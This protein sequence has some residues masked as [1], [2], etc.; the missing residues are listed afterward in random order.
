MNFPANC[1]QPYLLEERSMSE[2]FGLS[3]NNSRE[4]N[5]GKASFTPRSFRTVPSF[6]LALM[7]VVA[8]ALHVGSPAWAGDVEP[9][10]EP[11]STI[12]P[13]QYVS[14]ML[15]L[16]KKPT[17]RIEMLQNVRSIVGWRL[18][19]YDELY[20]SANLER[21]FGGE[22]SD[23]AWV[24]KTVWI[25]EKNHMDFI[26]PECKAHI[27]C[28][29]GSLRWDRDHKGTWAGSSMIDD[30]K[31]KFHRQQQ[32]NR[33]RDFT[34]L[35][36]FLPD[37]SGVGFENAKDIFISGELKLKSSRVFDVGTPSRQPHGNERLWITVD[38]TADA[39]LYGDIG[40]SPSANLNFV[41]FRQEYK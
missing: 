33:E 32:N 16:I 38:N 35:N 8:G 2:Q 12:T 17:T 14:K 5:S 34:V 21:V 40:F 19:K 22:A 18:L 7:L 9:R 11:F 41:S 10:S 37:D 31:F 36:L 25:T 13:A 28:F 20:T 15:A 1:G 6:V 23:W 26:S 24:D 4:N 27:P 30:V 3:R 29:N 39:K